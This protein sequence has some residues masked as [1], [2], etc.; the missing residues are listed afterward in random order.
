MDIEKIKDNAKEIDVSST[1]H[2]KASYPSLSIVNSSNNG[3]RM[4]FSKGLI[5]GLRNPKQ[6][7]FLTSKADDDWFLIIGENLKA[8]KTFKFSPAN[9]QVIYCGSYI[10]S[11]TAEFDLDFN[12]RTSMTF[13]D[14]EINEYNGKPAAYV[15][16]KK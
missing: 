14:I 10:Q 1:S 15:A 6:I 5:E 2:G 12:N 4:S 13:S 11:I 8:K 16:M 9:P 3:K 7:Q